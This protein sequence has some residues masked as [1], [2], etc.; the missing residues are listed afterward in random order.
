MNFPGFVPQRGPSINFPHQATHGA[1][2]LN[3]PNGTFVD[4]NNA[5][6]HTIFNQ[7]GMS[8]SQI[9]QA[10]YAAQYY[11][12][13]GY[14]GY[15]PIYSPAVQ[16]PT[17]M[18]TQQPIQTI[19]QRP[20]QV[21][22][23]SQPPPQRQKKILSFVDPTTNENIFEAEKTTTASQPDVPHSPS[24]SSVSVNETASTTPSV[25]DSVRNSA[26]EAH[27]VIQP[28]V[29]AKID[30][31]ASEHHDFKDVEIPKEPTPPQQPI[32]P[33]E[34]SIKE[35]DKS[36]ESSQ[37][38]QD[39]GHTPSIVVD[40]PISQSPIADEEPEDCSVEPKE[41]KTALLAEYEQKM[42]E[43]KSCPENV[44]KLDKQMYERDLVEL[45]REIIKNF[46]V[47]KCPLSDDQLK[48]FQ[49][50]RT[51]PQSTPVVFHGKSKY[52]S[53]RGD[54][55]NPS[56][57]QNNKPNI[58]M[59]QGRPSADNRKKQRVSVIARP[60]IQRPKVQ[61]LERGKGAWVPTSLKGSEAEQDRIEKVRKDIRG[62]LNKITPSTYHDLSVEFI[63]KKV[64]QDQ[65]SLPTVVELIFTKAVEEPTFVGIY[66]DLCRL[67]HEAELKISGGKNFY[68]TIIRKCQ[69]VFEGTQKT[70]SLQAIENVEEKLKA[71]EDPKK[72]EALQE[73][74]A[75]CKGKQKRYMLGT[76]KFIS[77]LYR[78]R[79]LHWK[80]ID[81]CLKSLLQS[82]KKE[83]D[84]LSVECFLNLLE[85]V[86]LFMH[87]QGQEIDVKQMKELDGFFNYIISFK[88]T[89]SNR[90]KFMIMDLEDLRHKGWKGKDTGPKTKEAVKADVLKEE[91]QNKRDRDAYEVASRKSYAGKVTASAAY[92]GRLSRDNRE[93]RKTQAVIASSNTGSSTRKNTKLSAV[94]QQDKLGGG[95]KWG[96]GA[97]IK[98]GQ[99]KTKSKIAD[100]RT[101]KDDSSFERKPSTSTNLPKNSIKST[102]IPVIEFNEKKFDEEFMKI[103]ED[104][105]AKDSETLDRCFEK[106]STIIKELQN[107]IKSYERML[108]ISC[109]K[110]KKDEHQDRLAISRLI[111]KLT[112]DTKVSEEF[113]KAFEHYCTYLV[114]NEIEEDVPHLIYTL[115]ETIAQIFA[116]DVTAV[117]GQ[118]PPIKHFSNGLIKFNNYGN[119]MLAGLFNNLLK[120]FKERG[121]HDVDVLLRLT[122]D[123]LPP[124]LKT[125]ENLSLFERSKIDF[126][127]FENLKALLTN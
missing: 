23:R 113:F 63:N 108:Y 24:K 33:I 66:S 104:Q 76:I 122:F 54:N 89:V 71:E 67:Q 16:Y 98:T 35:N 46:N 100:G 10:A 49:I 38:L 1:A 51:L 13:Y 5:D 105:P 86:G 20:Q 85:S 47:V 119:K 124:E 99:A 9:Q 101:G 43:Y 61:K 109:E 57:A 106:L 123:E 93:E 18:I 107:P 83:N 116:C 3:M 75:D 120:I 28:A 34:E 2:V 39:E 74:L 22:A 126:D 37:V 44:A 41:D 15:P 25:V 42:D 55:F 78:I 90:V 111:L 79:L 56:W 8:Y 121:E 88:A 6:G 117:D 50:D 48:A 52:Q 62:L 73:D 19:Q 72:R 36:R 70:S 45:I 112:Q 68:E 60:S 97:G 26:D 69:L 87:G 80:I 7:A 125:D 82:A 4:A 84:E 59:Y 17:Q 32:V 21:S 12:A 40:E 118:R 110:K 31:Q 65:E 92:G 103:L 96:S 11:N 53:G 127:Q 94:E 29:T 91:A 81:F 115:P 64:Y 114:D 77:H 102:P 58:K 14:G 95:S 27:S 30:D